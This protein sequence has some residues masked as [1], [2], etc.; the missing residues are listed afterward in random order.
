MQIE[1]F[2]TLVI[3]LHFVLSQDHR[4]DHHQSLRRTPSIVQS[5]IS[6]PNS[7]TRSE[8][9]ILADS[10]KLYARGSSGQGSPPKKAADLPIEGQHIVDDVILD[11][12]KDELRK[13]Q[14][15][16][17]KAQDRAV[18]WAAKATGAGSAAERAGDRDQQ[19]LEE[20]YDKRYRWA[21]ILG[22]HYRNEAFRLHE[23]KHAHVTDYSK[24]LSAG[25]R[26]NKGKPEKAQ[27]EQS[28][29]GGSTGKRPGFSP[30]WPGGKW[31][32]ST[33]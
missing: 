14:S 2:Y 23:E 5:Q 32:R 4:P 18:G 31:K 29:A 24:L 21:D 12:K 3:W 15:Q 30:G 20:K 9:R 33:G 11:R 26:Y 6:Q 1:F 16:A 10:R 17:F 22:K 28:P 27:P 13:L 25:I 19:G 8:A 7:N